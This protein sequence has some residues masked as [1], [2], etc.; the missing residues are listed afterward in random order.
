VPITATYDSGARALYVRLREAPVASSDEIS[1]DLV[2]DLDA[3]GQ[4]VG[5]EA[6]APPLTRQQLASLAVTY[7]FGSDLD[8]AWR[9][10][11]EVQPEAT[12]SGIAIFV[13]LTYPTTSAPV[14]VGASSADVVVK[15][16]EYALAR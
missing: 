12:R 5:I 4:P 8:A 3:D 1:D 6:L 2:V 15:T 9:A 14:V 10:V 13:A 11:R 7:G 16:H